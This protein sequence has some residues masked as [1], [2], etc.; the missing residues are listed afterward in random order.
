MESPLFFAPD[1]S[2]TDSGYVLDE[3]A[4]RHCILSL[5]KKSGDAILLTN[6]KGM[7][8]MAAIS[9][10]D[11][12]RCGVRIL[13]AEKIKASP[14]PFPSMAIPI[15]GNLARFEWFLE[16]AV[17][18]GVSA[19]HPL[20]TERSRKGSYKEARSRQIMISAMLQSRQFELPILEPM[21]KMEEFIQDSR[22]GLLFIAHCMAG[23]KQYLFRSMAGTDKAT[24]LIGPE[25]D[26]TSG[27]LEAAI[28]HGFIPVSLGNTRLRMETAAIAA[29]VMVHAGYLDTLHT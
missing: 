27:E 14:Y 15:A 26:F 1:L 29:L 9:D 28:I 5:R 17:E 13:S 19:I 25:G 3:N 7:R 6:G 11:S 21:Q 2:E 18:I 10:A 23:E 20:I 24:I 22:D 8:F 16:K 4:S 12:R